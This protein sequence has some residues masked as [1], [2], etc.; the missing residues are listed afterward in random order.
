M[1]CSQA[2][3]QRN[4]VEWTRLCTDLNHSFAVCDLSNSGLGLGRALIWDVRK[5]LSSN[6][7]RAC[8]ISLR[9]GVGVDSDTVDLE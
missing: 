7:I 6:E 9:E 5:F 2:V 3:P 8:K 4:T 1:K